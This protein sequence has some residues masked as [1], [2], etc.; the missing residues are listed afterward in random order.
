MP[1]KPCEPGD[2]AS[3]ER[4]LYRKNHD[5]AQTSALSSQGITERNH[6]FFIGE[7]VRKLGQHQHRQ[8]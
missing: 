4:G 3:K 6:N 7:L 1:V 5:H 8:L 2:S